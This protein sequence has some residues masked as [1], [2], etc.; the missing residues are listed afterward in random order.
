MLESFELLRRPSLEPR[1]TY[2]AW[3]LEETRV[4]IQEL[5]KAPRRLNERYISTKQKTLLLW[6]MP[7]LSPAMLSSPVTGLVL[8][9]PRLSNTSVVT[10]SEIAKDAIL[11]LD[12]YARDPTD[13]V[14]TLS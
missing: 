1:R 2:Q 11:M 7:L 6:W 5:E 8:G 14:Q 3:F 13:L 10:R 12:V 4:R 9:V